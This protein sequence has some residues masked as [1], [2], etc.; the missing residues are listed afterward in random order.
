MFIILSTTTSPE[1]PALEH[2]CFTGYNKACFTIFIP[3]LK[4]RLSVSLKPLST[5]VALTYTLPP[6]GTIPSSIAALVAHKASSTLSF[7]S[8]SST[9]LPAPI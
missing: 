4:S 9:S 1:I 5:S 3:V 8:L 2:I 6:P 7:F